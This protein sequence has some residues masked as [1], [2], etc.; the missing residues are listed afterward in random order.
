MQIFF[1]FRLNFA[2]LK[3]NALQL[4]WPKLKTKV[5]QNIGKNVSIFVDDLKKYKKDGDIKTFVNLVK[6]LP[7]HRKQFKTS[8]FSIL[9]ISEV[10]LI[11]Y[12]P[13]ISTIFII[14]VLKETNVDPMRLMSQQVDAKILAIQSPNDSNEIKYYVQIKN[15]LI[16]VSKNM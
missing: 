1:D 5:D 16:S 8:I 15:H 6:L 9:S 2:A 12:T 10:N 3:T 4:A 13:I 14:I 11:Q 7:T